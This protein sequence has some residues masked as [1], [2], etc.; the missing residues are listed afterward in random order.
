M[1]WVGFLSS[2]LIALQILGK[3]LVRMNE[4]MNEYMNEWNDG[5]AL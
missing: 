4:W 2:G 5:I 3:I 1:I